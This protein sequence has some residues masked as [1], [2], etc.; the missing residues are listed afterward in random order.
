[1][2]Q[3]SDLEFQAHVAGGFE[4]TYRFDENFWQI[5]VVAGPA[6]FGDESDK[7]VRA[8]VEEYSSFD[9]KLFDGVTQLDDTNWVSNVDRNQI[10]AIMA[11]VVNRD[12]VFVP[13]TA[14]EGGE[15]GN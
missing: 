6:T 13:E 4:S 8:T 7:E 3:F 2:A 9:Y 1:M 14:P 5:H 11:D 12:A 15:E 10:T